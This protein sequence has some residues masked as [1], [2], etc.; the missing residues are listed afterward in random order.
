MAFKRKERAKS[1]KYSL[2]VIFLVLIAASG[3]WLLMVKF[4][5]QAP[6][7]KLNMT[8]SFIGSQSSV[9]GIATDEKSGI[10]SIRIAVSQ[11][12]KERILTEEQISGAES[13][14]VRHKSFKIDMNSRDLGLKDGKALLK[15]SVRDQ[16]WRGW[17][18]GNIGYLEKEITIDTVAPHIEVISRQHNIRPGGSGLAIYRISEDCPKHGVV[19]GENFFP[20]HK[21]Y[22]D[23]SQI[24]LAF[25]ALAHD[26]G[27]DTNM[28]VEAEDHAGNSR[29]GGFYY[30]I[31]G[32]R[33]DAETFTISER[34]MTRILPEFQ[35]GESFPQQASLLDQFL[36]IN[37]ELRKKNNEIILSPKDK[38]DKSMHWSGAFSRLPNSARKAG[39]ADH[40]TYVYNGEKIDEQTHMGI[41]LASVSQAPVPAANSGRVAFV[42]RVGIYGN[43]VTIDHGFGLFSVYAHL[44]RINVKEDQMVGKNDI[45]GHTGAT[46]LAGGDHLHY[47]MFIHEVF[48]DPLEWWDPVWIQN[49]IISKLE[50]AADTAGGN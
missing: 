22:F 14:P 36:Y 33:F 39:F 6:E 37:R 23:D 5:G 7:I 45:I 43:L 29:R 3:I 25:F 19:V 41:D 8:D 16:S 31:R 24:C 38:T 15:I 10:R 17:F 12:E 1:L 44:S 48:V 18:S 27:Q 30:H 32:R 26:Q 2:L 40:R 50:H 20:G 13:G 9:T 28:Y 49:N 4:E 46:G 35:N 11:D 42:G 47:G 34:F 21:G